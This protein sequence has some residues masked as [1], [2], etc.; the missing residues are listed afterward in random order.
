M[1]EIMALKDINDIKCRILIYQNDPLDEENLSIVRTLV[2]L[3]EFIRK[4]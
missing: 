1:I 4:T 2:V 3:F